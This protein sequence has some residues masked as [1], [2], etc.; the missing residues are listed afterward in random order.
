MQLPQEQKLKALSFVQK[1]QENWADD[2]EK[3]R[4]ILDF[5]S[6]I[7]ELGLKNE[8]EIISLLESLLVEG[9][10]DQST[11]QI[12]Y[13]ALVNLIPKEIV[14][15]IE[16]GTCYDNLLSKLE[17]IRNSDDIETNKILGSEILTV[18]GAT[19]LMSTEQKLDFKAILYTFVY[20]NVESIPETE[21]QEVISETPDTSGGLSGLMGIIV[22]IA[23]IL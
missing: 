1:L 5:E 20:G 18:I 14:C 8:N 23:K 4:T 15:T 12:T 22:L 10:A 3:T 11:K 17:D 19:D 9:Q 6:Y 2:T 16:S 21:K 13:Q 7:F